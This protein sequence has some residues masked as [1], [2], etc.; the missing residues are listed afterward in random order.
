MD[1][2][3]QKRE[4]VLEMLYDELLEDGLDEFKPV[5]YSSFGSDSKKGQ[6]PKIQLI[7][8][9]EDARAKEME[10]E[11]KNET[12]EFDNAHHEI[13]KNQHAKEELVKV[14]VTSGIT[15]LVNVAWLMLY[16]HELAQTRIF[17]VEGTETSAAG[18]WLKQSFPKMRTL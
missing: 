2:V 9:L 12:L 15:V 11:L 14:L 3:K 6:Q 4:Q 5:A 8:A 7:I 17:E 1:D 13:D 16:K 18:K 10:L